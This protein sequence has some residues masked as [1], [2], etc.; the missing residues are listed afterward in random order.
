MNRM[1]RMNSREKIQRAALEA[2]PACLPKD[3]HDHDLKLTPA[4]LQA[5]DLARIV[6]LHERVF[7]AA[8]PGTVRHD[9]SDFFGHVLAG[10]GAILGFES[11]KSDLV[12]YG[13][14]T[15]PDPDE[16]HYGRILALPS[17]EWSLLAQLEGVSVDP[18]WQGQGL[19][20]RLGEWRI[21]TA[22]L[23]QYR[24][25]CATASPDNYYSWKNL[26]S[27][28]LTIRGLH[29]LYG[30]LPRYVLHRDLHNHASYSAGLEVGAR[31]LEH[32]QQLFAEGAVAYGWCGRAKP[33]TLLF[34]L[35]SEK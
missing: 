17:G 14:L 35:P 11:E 7:A 2:M 28:G 33:D 23:L 13:V 24:H 20:R 15:F 4:I 18:R 25:I 10:N 3:A 31:D 5:D 34:A 30:G 1:N 26:L 21:A 8:P 6:D 22:S 29:R 32:H 9:A 27:L 12:A 19:Q 16:M